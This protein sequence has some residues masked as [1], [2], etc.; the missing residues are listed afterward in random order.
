[1]VLSVLRVFTCPSNKLDGFLMDIQNYNGIWGRKTCLAGENLEIAYAGCDV[2]WELKKV[3]IKIISQQFTTQKKTLQVLLEGAA[4][5]ANAQC[6][7][8]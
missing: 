3:I 1:M 6:T 4:A 7:T 5:N 2:T 8:T